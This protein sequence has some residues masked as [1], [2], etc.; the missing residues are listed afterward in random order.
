MPV[1]LAHCGRSDESFESKQLQT[2]AMRFGTRIFIFDAFVKIYKMLS[3]RE[4]AGREED[5]VRKANNLDP[6]LIGKKIFPGN[7]TR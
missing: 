5:A 6:N 1:I 3:C 7:F 4:E 2:H